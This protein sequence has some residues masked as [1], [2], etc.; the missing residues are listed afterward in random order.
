VKT[1]TV[2]SWLDQIA[3]QAKNKAGNPLCH[4]TLKRIKSAISGIFKLAKQQGYVHQNPVH[5]TEVPK[6][7]KSAET[8]AYSL[9]E[10]NRMLKLMLSPVA[11]AI[12]AV[13]SSTGL[14]RGEIEALHWEDWQATGIRVT[15]SRWNGMQ[16]DPKT[17]ASAA[18][19]PVIP[20]LARHLQ[21]Y[22]ASLGNPTKG[23]MFP[24]VRSGKPVSINNVL[25]RAIKP[26]LKLAGI[27]WHGWHAFRRGLATNLHDQGVPDKTIQTILR[28]S[29]VSVTQRCYIKTLDKQTVAAMNTFDSLL[30]AECAP[31]APSTEHPVV[32]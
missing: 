23:P 31:N 26:A 3:D 11:A 30:C 8:H 14:R 6:G 32:N 13:A 2:Q 29:N 12:L 10:V 25:N 15:R 24:G 18:P 19:V 21:G 22:R 28:H 4:E 16:L 1:S 17:S 9:A 27:E 5:D 20:S 7:T